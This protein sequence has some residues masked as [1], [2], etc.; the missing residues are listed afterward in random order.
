MKLVVSDAHVGL[1]AAIS[2]MLKAT[3]QR[4]RVR[5]TRNLLAHATKG[6]RQMVAALIGT[7]LAQ[8][9]SEGT[10]AQW[11]LVTAQ[12]VARF[13]TLRKLMEEAK[14]DVLPYFDFPR[15]QWTKLLSTNTLEGLNG[16]AKRRS[17]VVRIFPNERATVRLVGA[18]LLEQNDEWSIQR[19][20]VMQETL[21]SVDENAP[22]TLP[23]VANWH[24]QGQR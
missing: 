11:G 5:F 22:V 2:K 19:R 21:A 20:Y 3:W 1:K 12:L 15:E 6:Q 17:G 10:R 23:A 13:P 14:Y 8:E 18:L 16:E 7:V 9:T 24:T 4:C